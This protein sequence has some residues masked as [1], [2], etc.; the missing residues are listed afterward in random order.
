SRL[1]AI[2]WVKYVPP[3]PSLTN[4]LAVAQPQTKYDI[5]AEAGY[6]YDA[7]NE[8]ITANK[9][10]P[11]RNLQMAWQELLESDAVQLNQLVGQ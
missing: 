3:S 11:S 7:V 5:Y 4:Q 2:G 10:T 9:T 1:V 8:L 6:W